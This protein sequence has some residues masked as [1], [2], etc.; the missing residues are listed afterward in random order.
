MLKRWAPF[1]GTSVA[2][3]TACQQAVPE[4]PQAC[5]VVRTNV[6][7]SR[8][9]FESSGLVMSRNTPGRFWTHNDSGNEPWL[10]LIDSSG[11]LQGRV[12]IA[13]IDPLDWEDLA[14]GPCDS[15]NC[16]FIG[17]IGDNPG[18]RDSISI[19]VVPEPAPTDSA[20]QPVSRFNLRYPDRAQDAEAMFVLP[21]GDIYIVTKGRR[22]S[23]ALY[24]L[25]KSAQQPNTLATL[26]RVRA[27]WPRASGANRA[28]GATTSIDGRWVAIRSY[29]ALYVF[30]ADSLLGTGRPSVIQDLEPLR[31]RQGESI[32]IS[33][34]GKVWLTSEAGGRD[35][36]PVLSELSCILP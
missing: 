13:G 11:A 7:I 9:V 35:Q 10:F 3:L 1:W 2:I 34:Q 23:V 27:L 25:P 30:A 22:D 6:P 18:R 32:A 19:Y 31:E 16:L 33:D 21:T 12:R 17:D 36:L 8:E 28:T 29:T 26:E 15:G 4:G 24:R 5:Q 14:A 20:T